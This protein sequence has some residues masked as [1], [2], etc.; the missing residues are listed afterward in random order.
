MKTRQTLC[1]FAAF[2]ALG[3]SNASIGPTLPGLAENVG[4][5]LRAIGFLFTGRSLGYLVGAVAGGRLYDRLPGHRVMFPALLFS[6]LLMLLIP[7]ISLLSLLSVVILVIGFAAGVLDVGGNTLLVWLHKDN[8]QANVGSYI[9]GLHLAFGVGAFAAPLLIIPVLW[10]SDNI[11]HLYIVLGLLILPIA[12]W[13]L[14]L[15]SPVYRDSGQQNHVRRQNYT[16]LTLLALFFV[17]Y[18]GAEVIFSGWIFTFATVSGYLDTAAAAYLTSAFWAALTLGR[19]LSIPLVSRL[20]PR[21]ILMGSMIG[22]LLSLWL[23]FQSHESRPLLWAGTFGYGL[24][25]APLFPV[26]LTFAGRYLTITA[27]VNS[28]FFA[29]ASLG[30]MTLPWLTGYLM[31]R[32]GPQI[33]VPAL[34]I[35]GC[36]GLLTVFAMIRIAQ[37]P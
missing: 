35:L 29:G 10:F 1:Y 14:M 33:F 11:T 7:F 13:V 32:F 2:V 36:L 30:A 3:F 27:T 4:V 28:W 17:I 24:F 21:R 37:R 8:R 12:A 20:A 16:L 34:I 6:A 9:T 5:S 23:I 15:P 31:D 22:C 18:A 26:T 25:M 19:L